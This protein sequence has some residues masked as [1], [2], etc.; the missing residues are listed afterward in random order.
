LKA[1]RI[2]VVENIIQF[3]I[4]ILIK[5]VKSNEKSFAATLQNA[6]GEG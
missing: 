5:T 2:I 4:Q 6:G 3:Q 1:Y